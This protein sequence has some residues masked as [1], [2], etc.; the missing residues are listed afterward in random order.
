MKKRKVYL[1][2]FLCLAFQKEA[3]L[4]Q[5]FFKEISLKEIVKKSDFIIK[6]EYIESNKDNNPYDLFKVLE[7]LKK[8]SE[9]PDT[10]EKII[11]RAA[12]HL[13]GLMVHQKYKETGIME[14]RYIDSFEPNNKKEL[15]KRIQYLIFLKQ[16]YLPEEYEFIACDG[17]LDIKMEEKIRKLIK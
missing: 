16:T 4:S 8:N 17:F 11:V 14:S 5:V 7:I 15:K 10:G 12:G 3:F 6:A 9:F 2:L 13:H 1:L